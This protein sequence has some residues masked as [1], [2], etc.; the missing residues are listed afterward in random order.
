MCIFANSEDPDENFAAYHQGLR[1]FQRQNLSSENF[2]SCAFQYRCSS[3][4]V[5]ID[6]LNKYCAVQAAANLSLAPCYLS[7]CE[8]FSP[9]TLLYKSLFLFSILLSI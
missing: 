1:C 7:R 4:N 3:H 5:L 2:T 9:L 6:M 8:H